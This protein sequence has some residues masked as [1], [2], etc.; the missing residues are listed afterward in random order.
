MSL[1]DSEGG[2]FKQVVMI[3]QQPSYRAAV[4]TFAGS[5]AYTLQQ[6]IGTPILVIALNLRANICT[7]KR[8]NSSRC[9]D[10]LRWRGRVLSTQIG[11]NFRLQAN[12]DC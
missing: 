10:F 7:A 1:R 6:S 12:Q 2:S 4:N 9:P 5:F 8:F 3:E 11:I